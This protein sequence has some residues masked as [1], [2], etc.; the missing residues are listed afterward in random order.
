M[1]SCLHTI[2]APHC[3]ET[4]LLIDLPLFDYNWL[5]MALFLVQSAAIYGLGVYRSR[6]SDVYS[7]IYIV[8]QINIHSKTDH[9]AQ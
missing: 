5:H 3:Q 8:F 2:T 4:T 9:S 7:Y 1:L 6:V